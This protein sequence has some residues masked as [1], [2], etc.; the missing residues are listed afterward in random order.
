MKFTNSFTKSLVEAHLASLYQTERLN[1]IDTWNT[2]CRDE[3]KI[4]K[5]ERWVL[6]TFPESSTN[7]LGRRGT[8]ISI[9]GDGISTGECFPITSYTVAWD[10]KD[11]GTCF[12]HFPV[13]IPY[14][15]NLYF[16][17]IAT[18]SIL[19]TSNKIDCKDRPSGTYVVDEQNKAYSIGPTGKIVPAKLSY[20]VH[21][22]PFNPVPAKWIN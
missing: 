22:K 9:A 20:L 21:K 4:Q 1:L 19:H 12:F 5:L 6:S 16:L 14:S 10:R 8:H 2:I 11:N 15:K 7:L 3:M 18:R 13:Y 17:N